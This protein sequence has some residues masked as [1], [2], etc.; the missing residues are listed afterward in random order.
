[1]WTEVLSA[2]F[3]T[4]RWA[5]SVLILVRWRS[6]ICWKWWG[7]LIVFKN[8]ERVWILVHI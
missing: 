8:M 4:G 3:T 7:T 6:P 2:H 1:M 5:S